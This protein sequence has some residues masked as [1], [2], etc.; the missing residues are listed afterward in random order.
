[1][2]LS[3]ETLLTKAAKA[4]AS[5]VHIVVGQPP[6]F[7][8]DGELVHQ[9]TAKI[10]K[11][12]SEQFIKSVI[13]SANFQR[14]KTDR[15][16]DV[17][18]Q[19]KNGIRLRVNCHY[20][21]GNVGFAARIIPT[22]IPNIEGIGLT[23]EMQ[24][25]CNLSEGLIL[26]TGPTGAGKSTSMAA[27]INYI[28]Q[29]RAENII[30]LEDPIEFIF[31]AGKGIVR[32]RQFG[33]D[34]LSF[35][36]ALRRVLRQDP[37]VIMVGEMRDLETIAAALTLAET[38]HLIIA[39]LH[40]PNAVQSIDRII[41]VFPPHQQSQIRTQLSF[42]LRAVI[43]QQ[44]LPAAEGGRVAVRECLLSTPAVSNII[45]DSRLQEL[46]SVIQSNSSIG[47]CTFEQDAKRLLKEGAIDKDTYEW[48]VS[49]V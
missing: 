18:H 5:D 14:L 44:L 17:S 30:T 32:Q 39:T 21:R 11:A 6:L 23:E 29:E 7:R 36:E 35:G 15:E 16:I 34:F 9:G 43:A 48:V 46:K 41:D 47:M 22:D 31:P 27:M 26:F 19:L 20:E 3:P 12:V 1:M 25:L 37:N 38:G 24:G 4:G 10:T 13:G 40:T 2:P 28:N 42:S 49:A 33:D 8:I 45:R